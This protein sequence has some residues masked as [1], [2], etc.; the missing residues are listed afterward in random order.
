[1]QLFATELLLTHVLLNS[2]FVRVLLERCR[3]A[4]SRT[5]L[6]GSLHL[7]HLLIQTFLTLSL[8][9]LS[10]FWSLDS[11]EAL[12]WSQVLWFV[13]LALLHLRHLCR[14]IGRVGAGSSG[15]H[16]SLPST[17]LTL[18]L[19]PCLSARQHQSIG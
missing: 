13:R 14:V 2:L 6:W 5:R 7:V 15:R 4:K 19:T 16:T 10:C 3:A 17:P 12:L 11:R 8:A 9:L 1:M 18:Q